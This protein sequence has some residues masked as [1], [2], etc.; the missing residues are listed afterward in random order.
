MYTWIQL[1][2]SLFTAHVLGT[3]SFVERNR[4]TV[5]R[6]YNLTVFPNNV[7]IVKHGGSS[8]PPGLF[9]QQ[10][11]GRI[12]PIGNFTGFEDSIE[13]FFALTP[14]ATNENG[15]IAFNKA[16]IRSFASGCPN[17]AASVVYLSTGPADNNGGQL[18][19]Q[20]IKK[21]KQVRTL[22]LVHT[23]S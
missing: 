6:I 1:V 20:E 15:N 4:K 10:A 17:I 12:S 7:P 3:P 5:E 21:L 18:V 9:S 11:T 14:V 19:G 22:L 16:D 23:Y 13:Y 8:V 2:V